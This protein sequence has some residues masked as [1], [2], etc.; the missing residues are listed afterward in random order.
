V[1][2]LLFVVAGALSL[3]AAVVLVIGVTVSQ[4][5]SA[6]FTIQDSTQRATDDPLI[7]LFSGFLSLLAL[8]PAVWVAVRWGQNR[9]FSSV[10]NVVGGVRWRWLGECQAIAVLVLGAAFAVELGYEMVTGAVGFGGFPGWAT[11]A[12]IALIALLVVPLQSAAEEYAF[13]GFLLQTFTAWFRTPWIGMVLSS[14]LFLMGHGYTDPLVWAQLFLMGM[15]SCWLA[16][17]TGGLEAAIA[18]HVANNVLSLLVTGLSGVPNLDQAGDFSVVDVLP[19]MVAMPVYAWI[20]D[21]RAARRE[22]STV[23]GGGSSISPIT[24]QV[25]R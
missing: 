14:L 21:R 7:V 12:K 16:V 8:V 10:S 4:H 6:G 19:F 11:Y 20:V 3:A 17:R 25:A 13:R 18:L 23:I 22:L 9:P 15:A 5:L 2:L 1:T 24:L